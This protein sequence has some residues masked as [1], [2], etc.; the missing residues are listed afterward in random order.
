MADVLQ[1]DYRTGRTI[2]FLLRDSSGRIWNGASFESYLTANYATYPITAAEQGTASGYYTAAWPSLDPGVYS[3][4]A[5]EQ[6]GASPA[7]TD[8]SVGW[9]TVTWGGSAVLTASGIADAVLSRNFSSVETTAPKTSLCGAGLKLTSKFDVGAGVAGDATVYQ[10][11][12]T[13]VFA[14]Q[15]KTT[16][17]SL[18]PTQTLGVMA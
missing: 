18:K 11:D 12:G 1:I 5:K 4:V 3:I 17:T 7:E 15:D 8:Y 14:T 2:Y 13:T 6:A 9:E 16:N 10:T